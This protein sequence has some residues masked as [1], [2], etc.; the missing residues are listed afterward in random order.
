VAVDGD[1]A[2]I[3]KPYGIGIAEGDGPLSAHE[4]WKVI[5]YRSE[6]STTQSH[7]A[8]GATGRFPWPA[9]AQNFYLVSSDADDDGD[10]AGNG[11]RTIEFY[12]IN[13]AGAIAHE[14]VTLNGTTVVATVGTYLAPVIDSTVVASAGSSG[15]NEGTIT[16]GTANPPAAAST[17]WTMGPGT[18]QAAG[19]VYMVPT[20]KTAYLWKV[21]A[22]E[23]S[24]SG[25]TF[26]MYVQEPGGLFLRRD[27]WLTNES[28]VIDLYQIPPDWPAGTRVEVT[29]QAVTGTSV[30]AVKMLGWTE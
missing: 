23:A 10:P 24:N 2:I 18:N 8:S 1:G 3:E 26:R 28:S 11:A 12:G 29:G 13:A 15:F 14:T 20:G 16:C 9:A 25:T 22:Q 6:L 19:S 21:L 5:G 7:L 30:A 17:A 4:K 27:V